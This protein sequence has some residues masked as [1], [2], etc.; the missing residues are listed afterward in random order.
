MRSGKFLFMGETVPFGLDNV[1]FSSKMASQD[2][3]AL[4]INGELVEGHD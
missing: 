3:H 1:V 4:L 2:H